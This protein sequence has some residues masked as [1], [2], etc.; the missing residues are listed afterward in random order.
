MIGGAA[1]PGL[2]RRAAPSGLLELIQSGNWHITLPSELEW[3]KAARGGSTGAIFPWGDTPDPNRANYADSNIGNTSA[4]G[5][6]PPNDYGLYDMVGNVWEWTR[7]LWGK[8]W[9]KSEFGYPYQP[10]DSKREDLWAGDGIRRVMRG[11]SWA[12]YRVGSRCAVRGWDWPGD[13]SGNYGFRVVVL[14]SAPV[15]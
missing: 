9:Q 14:C 4:V 2:R 7:S 11:G 10:D 8:D 15:V 3:E 13:R 6:F 1:S 5:C 12:D